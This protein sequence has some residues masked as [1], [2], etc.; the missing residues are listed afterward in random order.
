MAYIQ[1][2]QSREESATE[3]SRCV[4]ESTKMQYWRRLEWKAV[5]QELK[6][7]FGKGDGTVFVKEWKELEH[8]HREAER[9]VSEL[10]VACLLAVGRMMQATIGLVSAS[11]SYRQRQA[12]CWQFQTC[13]HQRFLESPRVILMMR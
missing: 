11:R 5:D 8:D 13:R 3:R 9:G 7:S 12:R 10:E 1:D 6:A 4:W 2:A